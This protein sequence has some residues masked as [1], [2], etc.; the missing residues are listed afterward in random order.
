MSRRLRATIPR[1]ATTDP[2]VCDRRWQ[3]GCGLLVAAALAAALVPMPPA[4]VETWYSRGAYPAIQPVVTGLTN[5]VA[6]S[7]LDV[8]AAAAVLA[9]GIGIWLVARAPRGTRWRVFWRLEIRACVIVAAG[10]LAFLALWGLNYQRVPLARQ[11][12]FD[13]ARVTPEA[14]R[15][16]A[17]AAVDEANALR[18]G[19]GPPP[20]VPIETLAHALAEPFAESVAALGLPDGIRPGRP[21]TPLVAWYF[22]AAGVS[23]M[24]NPLGL[25]T[26]LPGNLLPHERPI[27][28][29]H[30]WAHL[31]GLGSEAEASVVAFLVCQRA[32]QLARYSGWLHVAM[33]AVG[34]LDRRD[35]DE[36]LARLSAGVVD[37]LRAARARSRADEV[38][39]IRLAAW[40]VYDRY[41]RAHRVP[42]G[43]RS[44]DQVIQLLVGTRFDEGWVPVRG[45]T[46]PPR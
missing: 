7:C 17:L 33:R 41:L 8:L 37:D 28:L 12:A 26:L 13:A 43:I 40:D 20:D 36:A 15:R 16:L 23:G 3:I 27:V 1:V 46:R 22:R 35:R 2:R 34:N 30:E 18:D 39:W 38:R 5:T 32:N 9:I 4:A 6:F 21:K 11:L 42:G 24:T 14:V 19:L 25:E 31:A 44:Y 45:T 10:D 29:A